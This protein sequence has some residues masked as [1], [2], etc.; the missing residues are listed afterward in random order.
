MAT[1]QPSLQARLSGFL[2]TPRGPRHITVLFDTGATHCFICAR[3][4]GMLGLLPS[5]QPGRTSVTTE[6]TGDT[7]ELA[8]PVLIHLCLGDTFRE[9]MLVS[10]MDMDV[11]D[12]LILGLEWILSHD[13]RQLF[14]AGQ[15]SLLSWQE[16]LQLDLLPAAARPAPVTV[17]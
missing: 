2:A 9:S 15:I 5:D 10:P 17:P 14:V 13:L 16:L 8:A 3:L 4:A 1:G 6:A 7:L 11:G 12:D